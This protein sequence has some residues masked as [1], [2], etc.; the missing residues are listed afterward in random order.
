LLIVGLPKETARAVGELFMEAGHEDGDG[1]Q[2]HTIGALL[3]LSSMD[4]AGLDNY[5]DEPIVSINPAASQ[6]QVS[7]ATADLLKH[8]REERQLRQQRDRSDKYIDYLSAWDA[9]EGWIGGVYDNAFERTLADIAQEWKQSISTVENHYKSAFEMIT[10]HPYSPELWCRFMAPLKLSEL[11]LSPVGDVSRHRPLI[12]RTS[13]PVPDSVVWSSSD[14]SSSRR[15][16][17]TTTD[18][19]VASLINEIHDL[20]DGGRS[21]EEI[22]EAFGF[23]PEALKAVSYLRRRGRPV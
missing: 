22:V 10:G 4:A 15:K 2:P 1:E 19:D 5:V 8:W 21:N 7:D 11:A 14:E 17:A 12:T 18:S 20:I 13:R 16:T 23:S 9:R 6:R 3:H